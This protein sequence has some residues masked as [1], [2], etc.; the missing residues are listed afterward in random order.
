MR[1]R[2]NVETRLFTDPDFV[3]LMIDLGCQNAAIG[4]W[5]R[6]V[7]L[8]QEHWLEHK[9]IPEEKWRDEFNPL[10]EVNLVRKVD[11]GYYLRGSKEQFEWLEQRSKAGQKSAEARRKKKSTGVNGRSTELN[12]CSTGEPRTGTS[13]SNTNSSFSSII[14]NYNY[15]TPLENYECI[16]EFKGNPLIEELLV[17]VDPQLQQ[18]WL[19][20]CDDVEFLKKELIRASVWLDANPEK[21]GKKSMGSFLSN[22]LDNG[23]QR[24][25]RVL[26]GNFHFETR[27]E[28]E[29]GNGE[30]IPASEIPQ[31]IVQTIRKGIRK[32]E[33]AQRILGDEL[34]K[35]VVA[36]TT[37]IQLCHSTDM[38]SKQICKKI[39]NEF[40]HNTHGAA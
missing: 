26:P 15:N 20:L 24:L 35:A 19:V 28:V 16:S 9:M 2:I 21:R 10:V 31:R 7:I 32:N 8:A 25:G 29:L 37:W 36:N 30:T 34:W 11:G 6:V 12:D 27:K 38:E 39:Q 13:S 4:M 40:I 3:K 33:E 17:Q 22:W 5:L 23:I 1:G 18:K 14:K